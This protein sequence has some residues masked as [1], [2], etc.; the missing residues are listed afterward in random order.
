MTILTNPQYRQKAR[1]IQTELGYHDA[2]REATRLLE[3]LAETQQPICVPI[4]L[5]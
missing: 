1:H 4:Q 2:P 3:Q 5:S